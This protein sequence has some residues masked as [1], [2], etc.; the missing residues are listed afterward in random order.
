MKH[1]VMFGLGVWFGGS[2]KHVRE[3][4]NKTFCSGPQTANKTF[5]FGEQRSGP[6]LLAGCL[7]FL[8]FEGSIFF[9]KFI[10]VFEKRL[11]EE[12]EVIMGN[13]FED[14][15]FVTVYIDDIIISSDDY[16]SHIQ[17]LKQVLE[18]LN[19]VNLRA[20]VDKC[21]FAYHSITILGNEVSQEGIRPCVDKLVKIDSWEP[22]TTLKMLQRQLGFLNYFREYIPK[23]STIMAPIEKL[24]S[25]GNAIKWLPEHQK[26]YEKVKDILAKQILLQF[27]D[28]QKPLYVGTDASKYGI[29]AVL[30]Q[31]D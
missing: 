25:Q 8:V 6:A 17:H 14:M 29:A 4:E 12:S 24:R 30:Y 20:N 3:L 16:N 21:K 18:R 27:P 11:N 26:I 15:P 28:F 1:P 9:E 10:L 22:P 5:Q 23:Y 7:I 31:E 13:I 19:Q 2:R